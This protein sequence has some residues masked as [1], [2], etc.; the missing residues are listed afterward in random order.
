MRLR[1]TTET[2]ET[3]AATTKKATRRVKTASKAVSKPILDKR[4]EEYM[5]ARQTLMQAQNTISDLE[6]SMYLA[7]KTNGLSEYSH[8]GVKLSEVESKTN[9]STTIDPRKYY[10]AVEDLEE[11]LDTI[12]VPVTKARKV[13][14]EREIEKIATVVEG[15][16]T[17][18]KLKIA[19]P[20]V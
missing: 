14:S 17:G 7:M 15:R 10:D 9:K 19:L 3:A 20:K 4:I 5:A 11:F 16:V 18:K 8:A 1:R 2:T 13:L 6:E 12:T